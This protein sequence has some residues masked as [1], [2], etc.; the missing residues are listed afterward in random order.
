MK[1]S[2]IDVIS[3]LKSPLFRIMAGYDINDPAS[4][5]FENNICAF[6][7]GK[8]YFLSVAHNL[9]TH[10]NFLHTVDEEIYKTQILPGATPQAQVYLN[11]NY[12]L[13][14][15]KNKRRLNN[16]Q[17]DAQQLINEFSKISFDIRY[18]NLYANNICKPYLI[19]Q[20]R[21]NSFFGNTGIMSR[22]A[23][24]R[25]FFEEGISRNTFLLDLDL[26]KIFYE[27]D[28]A[29]YKISDEF[30]D[31]SE[32]IPSLP[33]DYNFY[34]IGFE[35]LYCLQGAPIN[36]LGKLLN[37]VEIEGV[38][39]HFS[40]PGKIR[41]QTY[42][43]QGNRYLIKGYFRFGSSGAPYLSYNTD[44]D[45]FAFNGIQS[46][47]SP[48]QMLINGNR[49]KNAQYVNAIAT[50]LNNIQRELEEIIT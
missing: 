16:T 43:F 30:M 49:D 7:I 39:D 37:K 21:S 5:R 42:I 1:Q 13:D 22:F 9:L 25:T 27:S 6:H 33:I 45:T 40:T 50:P 38:L 10:T 24:G 29:V 17:F 48:L 47:A 35:N 12:A 34:D 4:R 15:R 26:V 23:G 18:P 31:L 3:E 46:E 20:F 44:S 11:M 2:V 8:G 14:E 32:I 36:E 41:E 19:I 28:I